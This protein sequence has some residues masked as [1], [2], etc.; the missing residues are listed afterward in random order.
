MALIPDSVA[1]TSGMGS[2]R[3]KALSLYTEIQYKVTP[4]FYP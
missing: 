2:E 3:I 4:C 1:P